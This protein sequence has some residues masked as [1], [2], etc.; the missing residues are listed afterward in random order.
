VA[1]SPDDDPRPVVPPRPTMDD[2]CRGGCE[3]CVFD[4]YDEAVERY[5]AELRAWLERRNERSR[6]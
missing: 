3:P 4:L 5:E 2:C 1:D 6:N